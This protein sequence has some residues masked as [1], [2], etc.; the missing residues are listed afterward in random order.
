M[1]I[2]FGHN[3]YRLAAAVLFAVRMY[4]VF[5]ALFLRLAQPLHD[6]FPQFAC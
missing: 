5:A 1:N 6:L 4:I 3:H 2:T